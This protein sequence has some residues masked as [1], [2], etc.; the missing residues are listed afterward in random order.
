MMRR[1]ASGRTVLVLLAG[2]ALVAGGASIAVAQSTSD[3]I[4]VC[5]KNANGQPRFVDASDACNKTEHLVSW[6]QAGPPGP[7]GPQGEPGSAA[8]LDPYTRTA[9]F[10]SNTVVPSGFSVSCDP[11]DELLNGGYQIFP[12][13]PVRRADGR[14]SPRSQRSWVR[15]RHT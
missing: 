13:N 5:V 8:E 10:A 11:G 3:V 12:F 2:G 1:I 15:C 6:N 14:V 4:N 9:T 7:Q